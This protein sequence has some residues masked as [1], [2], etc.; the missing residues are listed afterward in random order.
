MK[1][2]LFVSHDANRAGAQIL[3]LRFLRL[4][5]DANEAFT[6][7]I[8]LKDG[9]IIEEDFKAV[10]PVYFWKQKLQSRKTILINKFIGKITSTKS[11]ENQT[12]ENLKA[13]KFDLVI[14][15]TI[16]NG[17]ILPALK[18]LNCPII[19]Y[20]HE[21]E[22]GIQQ[23][24]LPEH[25]RNVI[26]LSS[27][28]IACGEAVKLNLIEN[29]EIESDKIM[30]LPSLLPESALSFVADK[31]KTIKLKNQYGIPEDAFLVGG[32][33]TVDLR[34]GVDIFLQVARKFKENKEI[35][36]LWLGGQNTEIDY[37]I[38]QIDNNRLGLEN[39]VFQTSVSNPLDFMSSFD[40]FFVSSRE[41]PYPLVVLEA[42]MLEK[43]IICFDKAGGAKDFV[44]NDC[45]FIIDYLDVDKTVD[46]IVELKD[47]SALRQQMGKSG[48]KKVL[49]IHNQDKAF[50]TFVKIL[51]NEY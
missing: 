49:E 14:S 30:I 19:T 12:L 48:R 21:L 3:L 40:V 6:F 8:L 38:F 7:S 41:D 36:F 2:I 11:P 5:K 35:Y 25:F 23:Y 47:N 18:E 45:G 28:F 16:T 27:A 17:D 26:K 37:K 33:G 22:M 43:P 29:H 44:E 50:Q 15:N 10:A 31:E 1:N 13:Q 4:L 34:K 9:G 32:I 39:V 51:N 46:K 42:A 24:T 20:V